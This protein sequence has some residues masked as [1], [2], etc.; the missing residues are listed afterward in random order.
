MP[1]MTGFEAIKLIKEFRPNLPIIAQS[2]YSTTEKKTHAF[3]AG[4]D[5][6]ISKPLTEDSIFNMLLKW[7]PIK[8]E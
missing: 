7:L 5:D 3:S 2:A 6:F 1:V 4:C 8:T